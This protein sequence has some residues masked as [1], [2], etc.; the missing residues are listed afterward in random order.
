MKTILIFVS[1]LDG[2]VTRWGDARIRSWSSYEDQSHFDSVLNA[3]RV[4]IMGSGTYKPDPVKPDPKHLFIVMTRYPSEYKSL[5]KPGLVEFTDES[6]GSLLK[7]LGDSDDNI[8]IVGGP[9]ISAL[10]LKEKL[11][12]ELWLTIEPKIFGNGDSLVV[13]EKL[14]IE[15]KLLSIN[16]ANDRGT[17]ITKYEILKGEKNNQK[18]VI[19]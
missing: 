8:L 4:I 19:Q 18:T 14:D 1:T 9:Q 16:R 13:N 10:F 11:I 12:D 6:P 2:K 15:L 7:R 5:H 3:T 17:L